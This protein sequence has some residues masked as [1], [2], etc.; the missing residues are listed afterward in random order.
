MK[1]LIIKKKVLVVDDDAEIREILSFI[2]E[3][4]SDCVV[5]SAVGGNEAFEMVKDNLFDLILSDL[6]MPSG[7]GF[8]LLSQMKNHLK[9]PPPFVLITGRL[10]LTTK[11]V[12]EKGGNDFVQKPFKMETIE[13]ILKKYL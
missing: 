4:Y 7:C 13:T 3:S 8:S 9:S 1:D 6:D 11:D 2:V 12:L 5:T 10:G